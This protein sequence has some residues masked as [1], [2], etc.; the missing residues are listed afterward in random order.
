MITTRFNDSSLT[1]VRHGKILIGSR[2][3]IL[4][5]RRVRRRISKL[6]KLVATRRLHN[7]RAW[8]NG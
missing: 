6:V 7:G 2:V 8:L 4:D 5:Q 1:S 3:R